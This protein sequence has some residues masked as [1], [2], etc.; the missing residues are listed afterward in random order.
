MT[1]EPFGD[2]PLIRELQKI[3]ASGGGPINLELA[4][5]VATAVATQGSGD[6]ATDPAVERAFDEAAHAAEGLVAGYARLTLA[7]PIRTRA[8]GK[9]WW[10]TSTLESWRWLL[11]HLARRFTG[12]L[13]RFGE[14]D[15]DESNPIAAGLGQVAPVLIGIQTGTLI[16][17]L[18]NEALGRYDLPIPRDDDGHMFF[19]TPNVDRM[20]ADY[21]FDA[22]TF[23]KWLAL[24]SVARHLVMSSIQWS[25][26]Y[27]RSL[28]V[29]VV[30]AIELDTGDIERRFMD[31]QMRGIEAMQEGMGAQEALPIAPTERH[32]KALER[33]R[34]FVAVFEGYTTHV[35]QAVAHELLGEAGRI[36]EGMNRHRRSSSDGREMLSTLLGI[37]LDRA[38]ESS[39]VTFCAAV[40]R[41]KD[42]ASLNR[43]W[44]A[45][46]NLPTIDEIK[47][48]FSWME[49]VLQE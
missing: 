46:D 3:L 23:R 48:P 37:G 6:A 8:V 44:D 1:H 38:L 4:R 10:V 9:A 42:M 20:A 16:G 36:E 17:H 33:L 39:G 14:D 11:E 41:L 27:L 30:D 32:R 19:V 22:P 29:E 2:I 26:R 40:V 28:L 18:A 49:R 31:L 12:E 47:D 45:P 15:G 34:A 35:S 25:A 7:E 21:G 13:G 24:Q 5:Q 43:L